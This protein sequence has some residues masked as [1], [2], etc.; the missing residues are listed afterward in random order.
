MSDARSLPEA[1]VWSI[2]NAQEA[3]AQRKLRD[4]IQRA[5]T[6]GEQLDK[7]ANLTRV[8]QLELGAAFDAMLQEW[9]R[10]E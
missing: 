7:G 2:E 10:K 6:L 3:R 9:L 5:I 8:E 4:H 1:E